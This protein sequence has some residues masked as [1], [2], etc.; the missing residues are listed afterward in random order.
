MSRFVVWLWARATAVIAWSAYR[1]LATI[2]RIRG[3]PGVLELVERNEG[4]A[5]VS[6]LRAKGATVGESVRI[7]K[8]LVL[9]NADKDFSNLRIGNRVHIGR[10]VFLDLAAPVTLGDRTTIS[11][12]CTLITHMDPGDSTSVAASRARAR[13]GIE[14]CED[15]YLGAGAMV[16]CGVRIGRRAVVGAGAVVVREVPDDTIVAGV[17]AARISRRDV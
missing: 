9:Y 5:V 6:V 8:G 17:P 7:L 14:L 2:E 15:A 4:S 16:L 13:A 11:M 3:L 1:Y 10:E 12:R